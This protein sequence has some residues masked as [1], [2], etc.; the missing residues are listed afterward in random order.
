MEI[1]TD[2]LGLRRP[3]A[4]F[5][6]GLRVQMPCPLFSTICATQRTP[7][8]YCDPVIRIKPILD[9]VT[10]T[11]LEVTPAREV[12]PVNDI[13]YSG[14]VIIT[15][16]SDSLACTVRSERYRKYS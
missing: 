8:G 7:S 10:E 13:C 4:E 14:V 5:G 2:S 1:E 16:A 15:A 9:E 12:S 11:G 6:C 3:Y